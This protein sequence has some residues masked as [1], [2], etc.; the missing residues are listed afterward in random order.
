M[1][2]PPRLQ[3][4]FWVGGFSLRRRKLHIVCFRINA[5]THSF[6]CSSF[7]KKA[8]RLFGNPGET[9][10]AYPPLGYL[11]NETSLMPD[12]RF[13][14]N[15]EAEF[16]VEKNTLHLFLKRVGIWWLS[17]LKIFSFCVRLK[18]NKK[19]PPIFRSDQ[20][21][22]SGCVNVE[23][24]YYQFLLSSFKFPIYIRWRRISNMRGLFLC[25][26]EIWLNAPTCSISRILARVLR[27]ISRRSV[28]ISRIQKN[29]LIWLAEKTQSA[30]PKTRE[31]SLKSD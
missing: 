7:P 28:L 4:V 18:K 15:S 24:E 29:L 25:R 17:K 27:Q 20:M 31:G 10:L 8:F 23:P 11:Q 21:K 12:I 16:L 6:R 22:I 13:S 19:Q 3:S 30:V 1:S 26:N 9:V 2:S 14:R 5:K